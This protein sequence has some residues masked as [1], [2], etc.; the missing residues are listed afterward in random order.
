MLQPFVTFKAKN[1]R[2]LKKIKAKESHV[3]ITT[4]ANEWMD[5]KLMMHWIRKVL[6]KYT[7]RRYALLV[8]ETFRGI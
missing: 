4:Q 6:M 7:I 5:H 3:V 1:E 8:F 2:I